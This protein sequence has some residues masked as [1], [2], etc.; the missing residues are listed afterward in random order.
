M[1]SRHARTHERSGVGSLPRWWRIY[2]SM[3]WCWSV[4]RGKEL[5][6]NKTARFV[7]KRANYSLK[8]VKVP[9]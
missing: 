7:A 3:C 1:R 9:K 2:A 6:V 8:M 4:L 5:D